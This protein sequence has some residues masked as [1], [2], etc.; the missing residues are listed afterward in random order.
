MQG[1]RGARGDV[2]E[3][4]PHRMAVVLEYLRTECTS[5]HDHGAGKE[6]V[7]RSFTLNSHCHYHGVSI[8]GILRN[9]DQD[10]NCMSLLGTYIE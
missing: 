7:S 3:V 8:D 9:F 5:S 2:R 1:S 10:L 6:D 4:F